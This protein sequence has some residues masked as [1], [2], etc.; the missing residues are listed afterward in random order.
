MEFTKQSHPD[1]KVREPEEKLGTLGEQL[2]AKGQHIP[3][4]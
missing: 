1:I 3:P 2:K 4:P